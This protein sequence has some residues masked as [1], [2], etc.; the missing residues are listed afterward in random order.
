MKIK[1]ENRKNDGSPNSYKYHVSFLKK[2]ECIFF[3]FGKSLIYGNFF[4]ISFF[5]GLGN[6]RE[7]YFS[8]IDNSTVGDYSI[9]K[10]KKVGKFEMEEMFSSNFRKW[11]LNELRK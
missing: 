10:N 1:I 8:Y 5:D 11:V 9:A 2:N 6:L 3:A 7:T 4:D